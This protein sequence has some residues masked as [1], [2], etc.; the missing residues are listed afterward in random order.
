MDDANI[1]TALEKLNF[2]MTDRDTE[3]SSPP[4]GVEVDYIV[5]RN[6]Q[7]YVVEAKQA[8][9][10]DSFLNTTFFR[11]WTHV[12]ACARLLDDHQPLIVVECQ[13][14]LGSRLDRFVSLFDRYAPE[15]S[16]IAVE[17]LRPLRYRIHEDG[18]VEEE[19]RPGEDL[20][21]EMSV[22]K[23]ESKS[24]RFSDLEL[25]MFKNMLFSQF[26]PEKGEDAFPDSIPNGNQLSEKAKV[27]LPTVYDWLS[28]MEDRLFL[29][30]KP[31]MSM[32]L[33][34]V[35][36][37]LNEWTMHYR[38]NE[39]SGRLELQFIRTTDHPV[40]H[41]Q[42][43][44]N[45]SDIPSNFAFTGHAGAR[46]YDLSYSTAEEIHLFRF[47]NQLDVLKED[48]GLIPVKENDV[49]PDVISYQPRFSE[50]VQRGVVRMDGVPVV[51]PL[52]LYLDCYH[53]SERGQEQAAYLLR[54]LFPDLNKG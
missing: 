37:Y 44:F 10:P 15:C 11:A 38:L 52:Q 26:P 49:E 33:V 13:E 6:G 41:L 28:A 9:N 51:D 25:W 24:L 30:R 12:N 4:G 16:W 40:K 17:H 39:N 8:S 42:E 18:E 29:K 23:E 19:I 36:E 31:R 46:I 20:N 34:N 3:I 7:R 35:E 14:P 50:A 43:V 21:V 27:S 22:E 53:L 47:Q 1:Q 45:N 54:K 32:R 48:L 2:E 5:Q